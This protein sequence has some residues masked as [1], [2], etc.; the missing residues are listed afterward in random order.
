MAARVLKMQFRDSLG[1]AHYFNIPYAKE[2]LDKKTVFDQMNA[3]A[4]TKLF[5]KDGANLLALPLGASLISTTTEIIADE[6]D[7]GVSIH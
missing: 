5:V 1:K 4:K 7:F 6:D 2:T 3:L